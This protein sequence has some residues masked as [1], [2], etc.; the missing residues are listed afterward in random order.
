VGVFGLSAL[1]GCSGGS[2]EVTAS[3]EPVAGAPAGDLAEQ[4]D[5]GPQSREEM[6][7]SFGV[8]PAELDAYLE[9]ASKALS[10][11]GVKPPDLES[12]SHSESS[13]YTETASVCGSPVAVTVFPVVDGKVVALN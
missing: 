8:E 9:Q 11:S 4:S 7:K 1:V 5:T 6:A 12:L 3:E 2:T 10:E 13:S